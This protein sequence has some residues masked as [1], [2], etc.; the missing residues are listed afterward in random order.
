MQEDTNM[1]IIYGRNTT[2][3]QK[4]HF[5]VV[6]KTK[7]SLRRSGTDG[8]VTRPTGSLSMPLIGQMLGWDTWTI[9]QK[10]TPPM[11]RRTCKGIDTTIYLRSVNEDMQAP[12]PPQRPGDQDAKKAL[13][14]VQKQARQ[15][16]GVTFISRVARQRL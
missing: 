6:R 7:D 10:S 12:P 16:C 8:K 14:D 11:Q 3:K 4:R 2:T 1:A 9:L 5:V 13:V 15:D